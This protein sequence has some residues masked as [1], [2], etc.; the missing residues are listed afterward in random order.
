VPFAPGLSSDGGAGRARGRKTIH[1]RGSV[2]LRSQR[3]RGTVRTLPSPSVC[4]D[5]HRGNR[6][7]ARPNRG[8]DGRGT[9]GVCNARTGAFTEARP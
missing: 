8:G 2:G 1:R 6:R 5:L 3:Y 4:G 7:G 9:R